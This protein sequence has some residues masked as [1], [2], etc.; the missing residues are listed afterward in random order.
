MTSSFK[1]YSGNESVCRLVYVCTTFFFRSSN[2][3][4]GSLATGY[5]TGRGFA[6]NQ[7]VHKY[8]VPRTSNLLQRLGDMRH[9]LS[10]LHD[11]MI[12]ESGRPHGKLRYLILVCFLPT[13]FVKRPTPFVTSQNVMATDDG[14]IPGESESTDG[15]IDQYRRYAT[16]SAL[17]IGGCSGKHMPKK[18]LQPLVLESETL[19]LLLAFLS[20]RSMKSVLAVFDLSFETES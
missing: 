5:C 16:S 20:A 15:L 12:S 4:G 14:A 2:L 1:K 19:L 9:N 3:G 17:R 10:S 18:W 8:I 6:V 7:H 13:P 11:F